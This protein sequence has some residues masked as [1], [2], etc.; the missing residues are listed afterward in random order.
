MKC[1][2]TIPTIA[3]SFALSISAAAQSK[4]PEKDAS[5]AQAGSSGKSGE[6][7][8]SQGST[9]SPIRGGDSDSTKKKSKKGKKN[10][11]PEP[12]KSATG[13]GS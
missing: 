7:M 10:K 8:G 5:G 9:E 4:P 2:S 13:H 12:S 3:L 11:K 6:Q 1:R